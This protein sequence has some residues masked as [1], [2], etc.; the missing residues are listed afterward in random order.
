MKV[1]AIIC[2]ILLG[3]V[4]VFFGLNVFLNFL[5][6][7]PPPPGTPI[8]DFTNVMMASGWMKVVG[9]LQILGGLLVWTGGL[10]PLGLVILCPIT[11][12][13]LLFHSLLAGGHGI[14]PGVITAL[15]ELILIV[16]YKSSFAGILTT[17]AT[18]V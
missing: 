1:L 17:K 14:L 5:H 6:A 12:N 16:C 11:L 4:F 2:R 15:L 10:T 13:I 8:G 18:T 9:A 7:A 3:L